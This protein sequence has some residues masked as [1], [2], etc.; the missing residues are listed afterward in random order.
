MTD[1]DIIDLD[2][3]DMNRIDTYRVDLDNLTIVRLDRNGEAHD[4][5]AGGAPC[6]T[7]GQLAA[8]IRELG[9][10]GAF[11]AGVLAE[12]LDEIAELD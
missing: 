5:N 11:D 4:L 1:I 12:L 9:R 10:Q 6:V 3:D 2:L 7:R 8:F